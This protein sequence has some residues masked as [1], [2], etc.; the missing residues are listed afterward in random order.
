MTPLNEI[1][2]TP[3]ERIGLAGIVSVILLVIG[4]A[5]YV[6]LGPKKRYAA[7]EAALDSARE[8]L[9]MT[10]LLKIDEEERLEG[11]KRLMRRLEQRD[12]SFN[13]F[14]FIND[15]LSSAGLS[16]RAQTKKLTRR[17]LSDKQPLVNVE[18][19]EVSLEELI[20]FLHNVYKANN[21]VAIYDVRRITPARSNKG[22]NCEFTFITIES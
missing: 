13:L 10:E 1:Q 16:D 12:K 19:D 7:A 4:L 17:N 2:L 21:L 3:R 18:I 6:P 5:F 11:Q 9:Q 8:E 15:Q 22:L 20:T 14:G